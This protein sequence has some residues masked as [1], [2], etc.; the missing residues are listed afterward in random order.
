[1][2]P[3]PKFHKQEREFPIWENQGLKSGVLIF[4]NGSY[5]EP[6]RI[7]A[8]KYARV[9]IAP[10]FNY[11]SDNGLIPHFMKVLAN[12]SSRAVENDAY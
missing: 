9:I 12:H 2:R 10:H 4:A 1:M 8:L 6:A 7:L 5:M 3:H 11:L